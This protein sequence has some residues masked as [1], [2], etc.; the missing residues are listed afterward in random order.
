MYDWVKDYDE[1]ELDTPAKRL[2][3]AREQTGM[4]RAAMAGKA[5]VSPRTLEKYEYGSAEPSISKLVAICAVLGVDES[6]IARGATTPDGVLS[7]APGSRGPDETVERVRSMLGELDQARAVPGLAAMPRRAA[8]LLRALERELA[9]VECA[10]LAMLADERCLY[11][12]TA[13]IEGHFQAVFSAL[14]DDGDFLAHAN[15]ATELAHR[16]ADTAILG[17]DLHGIAPDVLNVLAHE[18]LEGGLWFFANEWSLDDSECVHRLRLV[19]RTR[20]VLDGTFSLEDND[21]FPKRELL[22]QS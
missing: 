6:F 11:V 19:L 17:R 15:L 20:V 5:G 13:E 18:L 8:G 9:C 22:V 14:S 16:I 21:K 10:E 1:N 12:G 4:S 3:V 7:A 2:K